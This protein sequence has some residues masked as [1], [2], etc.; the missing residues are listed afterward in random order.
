MSQFLRQNHNGRFQNRSQSFGKYSSNA[1][2]G[3]G[4]NYGINR[5]KTFQNQS[6][7][8]IRPES[9]DGLL[10]SSGS[11]SLDFSMIRGTFIARF[12]G[13]GLSHFISRNNLIQDPATNL[14]PEI[15]QPPGPAPRINDEVHAKLTA[16]DLMTTTEIDRLNSRMF[17]P[18]QLPIIP[19]VGV[20]AQGA[21]RGGRGAAGRGAGAGAAGAAAGGAVAG[22]AAGGGAAA[23]AGAHAGVAAGNVPAADPVTV[24]A[25]AIL[26]AITGAALPHVTTAPVIMPPPAG[27][28]AQ[29]GPQEQSIIERELD[30]YRRERNEGRVKYETQCE[31]TYARKDK[32][33]KD[34]LNRDRSDC[35]Q[36]TALF[37]SSF[38][39]IVLR[40]AENHLL[41]NQFVNAWFKIESKYGG[42]INID[43]G[44]SVL[45]TLIVSATYD[46]KEMKKFLDD[47]NELYTHAE[48]LNAPVSDA[49][50][51]INLKTKL[52]AYPRLYK[53]FEAVLD[54]FG[55]QRSGILPA[56]YEEYCE[57]L[58]SKEITKSLNLNAMNSLN[59]HMRGLSLNV[60]TTT[61]EQAN[62]QT[63]NSKA[64][65]KCYGCQSY[66]HYRN[67]PECP[68]NKKLNHMG[69]GK[70]GRGGRGS[71]GNGG[72]QSG[73]GGVSNS[74]DRNRMGKPMTAS[75]STQSQKDKAQNLANLE[76]A[77]AATEIIEKDKDAGD[78]RVVGDILTNFKSKLLR[79]K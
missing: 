76:L 48:E 17:G 2:Q 71:G 52:R 50:K 30:R 10:Y 78:K 20:I 55:T 8:Y 14:F 73:R 24:A 57:A 23:G 47:M 31:E 53:D 72:R 6:V 16:Y 67:D 29:L 69:N 56:D 62:H 45:R 60:T 66:G 13:K 49:E 63:E 18:V 68:L 58:V 54:S 3:R 44:Q 5:N 64:H 15:I 25:V 61:T 4:N 9:K 34:Q 12:A 59:N 38:D 36:A 35:G 11:S 28:Y 46:G 70:A 42:Q 22:A 77:I 32:M 26:N 41:E 43:E 39:K 37:R 40:V 75:Q 7:E 51:V 21:G 1:S 27:L 19:A 79:Y 74:K 65:I 33:Y